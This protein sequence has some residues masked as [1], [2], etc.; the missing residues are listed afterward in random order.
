MIRG[1]IAKDNQVIPMSFDFTPESERER[2]K[3]LGLLKPELLGNEFTA[4]EFIRR[5]TR[6]DL[7][8]KILCRD[9]FMSG[10]VYKVVT[11]DDLKYPLVF[12]DGKRV[13]N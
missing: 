4:L 5:P 1:I 6:K 12:G 3:Y 11:N 2:I 7:G 8:K 13:N 9:G 10:W